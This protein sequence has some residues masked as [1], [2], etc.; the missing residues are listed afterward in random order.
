MWRWLRSWRTR[1]Y[2]VAVAASWLAILEASTLKGVVGSNHE[3]IVNN[4]IDALVYALEL[5]S[6]D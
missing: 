1:K 6:S 5:V 2:F 4:E 3:V